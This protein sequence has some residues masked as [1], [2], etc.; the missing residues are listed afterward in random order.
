MFL[1]FRSFVRARVT[2]DKF[3]VSYS[4]KKY[5]SEYLAI[6]IYIRRVL[7]FPWNSH[8]EFSKLSVGCLMEVPAK[9]TNFHSNFQ[10]VASVHGNR[11]SCNR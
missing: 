4:D 3:P 10:V 11:V 8:V 7:L 2:S 6:R 9:T 5:S 1:T